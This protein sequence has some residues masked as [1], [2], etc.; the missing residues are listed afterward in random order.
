M[1]TQSR[2]GKAIK[3]AG[4]EMKTNEEIGWQ[5]VGL[6]SGIAVASLLVFASFGAALFFSGGAIEA[7]SEEQAIAAR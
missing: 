3:L 6:A 1:Q 5:L 4:S 2:V 7:S